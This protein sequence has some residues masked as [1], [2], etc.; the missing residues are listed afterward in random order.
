M[1]DQ[2]DLLVVM[3]RGDD[4]SCSVGCDRDDGTRELPVATNPKC[5]NQD[6]VIK[7]RLEGMKV[8]NLEEMN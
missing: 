7:E 6:T 5:Y 8:T 4:V 1:V 2:R 3:S